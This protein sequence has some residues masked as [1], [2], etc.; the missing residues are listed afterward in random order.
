MDSSSDDEK[1]R[2]LLARA[3][4]QPG[5]PLG[6]TPAAIARRGRRIRLVRWGAGVTGVVV[7]LAG[8]TLSLLLV[9]SRPVE[10]ASPP[11]PPAPT[12]T[13]TTTVDATTP[14][15]TLTTSHGAPTPT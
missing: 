10:P 8:V 6:F 7:V 2:A 3:G 1:V 11:S 15:T 5:P 4:D 14:T 12:S 13:V 9:T